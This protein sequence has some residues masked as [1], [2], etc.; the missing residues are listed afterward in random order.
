[1]DELV[2]RIKMRGDLEIYRRCARTGALLDVWAKKNTITYV[3]GDTLVALLAPNALG[4]GG[5]QITNQL[6]SMRFGTSSLAPNRTDVA[7][8][9]EHTAA[10]QQLLD[11]NRLIGASGSVT[12]VTTLDASTGNGVTYREAGLFTRGDADDPATSSGAKLF[13]RQVFPD[14][15]KS[16]AIELEFRWRL[17]FTV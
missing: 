13:A 15:A 5:A 9:A 4:T 3:A 8:A 6:K 12:F 14:Q 17:T 10:R 16:A 11:A 7:L 2:S 1:M